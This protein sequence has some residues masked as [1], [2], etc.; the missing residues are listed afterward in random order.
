MQKPQAAFSLRAA[1]LIL[2][3]GKFLAA[4]HVEHPLYYT[5][6]GVV[7]LNETAEE[8]VVRE[9]WEETGTRLAIERL[10]FVQER[11]F[12]A[13]GQKCQEIVFFYLMQGC[14]DLNIPD[15]SP[16]DQKTETLHWLPLDGLGTIALVPEF[17][18]TASFCSP[19]IAHIV[20]R[21]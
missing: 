15:G 8:A 9:V 1:A 4:K 10:A 20:S 18:K 14:A 6:G 11:F 12:Q 13:G 21:E 17:L 2:K 5:V 3:D 19:G 16:T 7:E